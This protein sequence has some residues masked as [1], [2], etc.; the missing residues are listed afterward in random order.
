MLC[1]FFGNL[2]WSAYK[3]RAK[4][5]INTLLVRS[6]DG[7][8]LMEDLIKSINSLLEENPVLSG[9]TTQYLGNAEVGAIIVRSE[10]AT[11]LTDTVQLVILHHQAPV[12]QGGRF[13][14]RML[15]PEGGRCVGKGFGTQYRWPWS[16]QF[17]CCWIPRHEAVKLQIGR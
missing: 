6:V 7:V 12:L 5:G 10:G 2:C 11:P 4:T 8:Q 3:Q 1:I 14:C 13:V 17:P 15:R 16:V 9:P